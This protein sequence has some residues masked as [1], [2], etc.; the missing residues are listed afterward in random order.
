[1]GEPEDER[2]WIGLFRVYERVGDLL[3]LGRAERRLR[4]SLVEIAPSSVKMNRDTV[5][6]PPKLDRLLHEVRLR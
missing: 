1:V 5:T 3:G 6:L 4:Q 2:F